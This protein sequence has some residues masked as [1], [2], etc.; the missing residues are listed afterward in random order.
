MK[1]ALSP[2][3]HLF[4]KKTP[5]KGV[6]HLIATLLIFSLGGISH[7]K[8]PRGVV[9]IQPFPYAK[10]GSI[11]QN[12]KLELNLDKDIPEY[13]STYFKKKRSFKNV[14]IANNINEK[15]ADLYIEGEIVQVDTGNAGSRYVGG[16]TSAGKSRIV[17]DIKIYDENKK[18]LTQGN[19]SQRGSS[20][21]GSIS[22]TFSNRANITSAAKV[23]GKHVNKLII[24]G[25]TSEPSSIIKAINSYKS[26]PLRTA[27]KSAYSSALF[28]EEEITDAM[29]NA[30]QKML[31]SSEK[32]KDKVLL[33][34]LAWCAINLGSSENNKYKPILEAVVASNAHRKVKKRA[35]KSLA[36]LIKLEP[37]G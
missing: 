12:V 30:L 2:L 26:E 6:I 17:L 35:K 31:D 27:A 8:D 34:G 25:N 19:V 23:I 15:E 14:S 3:K 29:A 9:I 24:T 10:D 1:K 11:P 16:F 32:I 13:I 18:L 36:L 4:T 20:G 5:T 37:Q 28:H 22:K 21:F 7:A 33:D